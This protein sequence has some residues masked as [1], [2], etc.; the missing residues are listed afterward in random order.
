MLGLDSVDQIRYYT[1]WVACDFFMKSHGM[2][3]IILKHVLDIANSGV[4]LITWGEKHLVIRDNDVVSVSCNI[5]QKPL[6]KSLN[7]WLF[8]ENNNIG[9]FFWF[10][11]IPP[12]GKKRK[13]KY[14]QTYES[15]NRSIKV[16]ALGFKLI[17]IISRY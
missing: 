17:W 12:G 8:A 14:I 6:H 10:S 4:I 2:Q 9:V 13:K 16:Y 15:S 7:L 3:S 5:K 11:F 1:K